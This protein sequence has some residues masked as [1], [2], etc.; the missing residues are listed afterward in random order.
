MDHEHCHEPHGFTKFFLSWQGV[1]ATAALAVVSFYLLTQHWEHIAVALPY[2]FLLACP[3]M[4]IFG[5]GHGHH[6]H[7]EHEDDV[8]KAKE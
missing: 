7:Q 4:H 8:K 3:L 6:D 2:L 5:H 1:I